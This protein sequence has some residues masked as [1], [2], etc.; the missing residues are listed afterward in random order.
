MLV[1]GRA[2]QT[3][4]AVDQALAR[5]VKLIHPQLLV[6]CFCVC[7][8]ALR[9]WSD[10]GRAVKFPGKERLVR[11]VHIDVRRSRRS[12]GRASRARVEWMSTRA[13]GTTR[14]TRQAVRETDATTARPRTQGVTDRGRIRIVREALEA[15][16]D[17]EIAHVVASCGMFLRNDWTLGALHDELRKRCLA[18]GD[19]EVIAFV[20]KATAPSSRPVKETK[21]MPASEESGDVADTGIGS[22]AADKVADKV[23]DDAAK[24]EKGK[25]EDA[26][27][28][29]KRVSPEAVQVIAREVKR[30]T[31]QR[32]R[33]DAPSERL[34]ASAALQNARQASRVIGL[35][36]N[37]P[38][39]RETA[40]AEAT[41]SEPAAT[42][43]VVEFSPE[44]RALGAA[45]LHG[46]NKMIQ[47][48]EN[49][50]RR[51]I[52]TL[53]G[54]IAATRADV[55]L[56]RDALTAFDRRDSDHSIDLSD[57]GTPPPRVTSE[58]QPTRWCDPVARPPPPRPS[59]PPP[60][61]RDPLRTLFL[62]AT[63]TNHVN[64]AHDRSRHE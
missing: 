46:V 17:C 35:A 54:A 34:Q 64:H 45:I 41:P 13:R 42:R 27:V 50:L 48:S 3:G 30:R 39:T 62:A 49:A 25:D 31:T 43:S 2:V 56:L 9:V 11:A 55:L 59:S 18:E 57:D 29:G 5:R 15:L 6:S 36:A 22:E 21:I 63:H 47:A 40:R 23:P 8:S 7:D 52:S 28:C 38:T 12:G 53:V 32:Y 44:S 58:R 51:D 37:T 14:A 60:P 20:L 33:S 26:P 4:E 61:P 19:D 24:N 16:L 10:D 1:D